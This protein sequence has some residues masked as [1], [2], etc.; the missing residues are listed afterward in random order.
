MG[1]FHFFY[2]KYLLIK[3]FYLVENFDKSS[4]INWFQSF[5]CLVIYFYIS[6]KVWFFLLLILETV[7]I[8]FAPNIVAIKLYR[9]RQ[10]SSYLFYP[11]IHLFLS[12]NLSFFLTVVKLII[13]IHFLLFLRLIFYESFFPLNH[14]IIII[15]ECLKKLINLANFFM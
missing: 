6:G 13:L 4:T 14:F 1:H 11:T 12:K 8:K 9:I 10:I 7:L 3:I 15:K 2:F 5:N